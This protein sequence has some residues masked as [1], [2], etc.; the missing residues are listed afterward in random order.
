MT[1]SEYKDK[2]QALNLFIPS[3]CLYQDRLLNQF[4]KNHRQ[5]LIETFE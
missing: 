1:S 4:G 3:F 5:Q 2:I